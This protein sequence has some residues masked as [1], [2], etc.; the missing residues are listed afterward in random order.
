MQ[1]FRMYG[2]F[3]TDPIVRMLSFEDQRHFVVVLCL[4]SQGALD[5]DY[6]TPEIRRAVLSQMIGLSAEAT[7]GESALDAANARLRKLGLIDE[8]WQPK[9]WEKRQ[10]RSDHEDR[11]AAERMRRYRAK[12]NV[13]DVTE[14]VTADVT[15][16]DTEQIQNRTEKKAR[17]RASRV[18]EDFSPDLDFARTQCPGIDLDREVQ[19]F[20]DHEFKNPR[21]DWAACWRTWIGNCRDSGRFARA[22]TTK[23][24]PAG[25]ENVK[26]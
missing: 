14:I 16:L 24:V 17:K 8:S 19:K 21:S 9:N 3:A 25:Y 4:K 1:W 2:E 26:W 22:G 15:A 7:S 11:T 13:T 5:K 18:P 6:P 23:V 20:R 10:F 12:R